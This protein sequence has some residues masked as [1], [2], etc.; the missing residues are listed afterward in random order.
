[1][2]TNSPRIRQGIYLLAIAAQIAS[3]FVTIINPDL[4]VAFVSTAGLLTVVA[5]G[6]A[7]S[8]LTPDVRANGLGGVAPE[9]VE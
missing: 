8:N 4:A 3:F 7:L 2:F 6:T 1:M 5:G 9:V